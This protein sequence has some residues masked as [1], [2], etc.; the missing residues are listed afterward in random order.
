MQ[1][2]QQIETIDYD[3]LKELLETK[4]RQYNNHQFIGTDPVSIPHLFTKNEDVEIAGFLS[5][6]IAF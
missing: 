5:S 1:A 4:A 3:V 2:G 6:I